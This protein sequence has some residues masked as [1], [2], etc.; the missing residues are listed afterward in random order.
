MK[1]IKKQEKLNNNN[2]KQNSTIHSV[3]VHNAGEQNTGKH[4]FSFIILSFGFEIDAKKTV[5]FNFLQ[6][7]C[8]LI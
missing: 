1:D 3:T 6:K 7:I 8:H 2:Q 4:F 5:S